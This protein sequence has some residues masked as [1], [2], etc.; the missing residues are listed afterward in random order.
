MAA[1][2]YVCH[3]A[4]AFSAA[5]DALYYDTI[6]FIEVGNAGAE[7]ND[8]SRHLMP[9]NNGIVGFA[10]PVVSQCAVHNLEVSRANAYMGNTYKDFSGFKAW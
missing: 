10:G 8:G 9:G 4:F 5:L 7:S 1:D 3:T 6:S 2:R